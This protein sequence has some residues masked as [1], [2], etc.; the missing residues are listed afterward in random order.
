[1]YCNM[2]HQ[3]GGSTCSV[4][5]GNGELNGGGSSGGSGNNQQ[6]AGD[7][8]TLWPAWVYCTRYSDRPSSGRRLISFIISCSLSLKVYRS[9][10]LCA[11]S[12]AP[13]RFR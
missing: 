5:N 3:V 6:N 8:E 10:Y 9:C 4:G 7:K 2:L 11:P 1:M 12:H 13:L